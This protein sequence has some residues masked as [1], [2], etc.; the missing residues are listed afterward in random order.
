MERAPNQAEILKDMIRSELY[1]TSNRLRWSHHYYNSRTPPIPFS[2]LQSRKEKLF[3][4]FSDGRYGLVIYFRALDRFP[5]GNADSGILKFKFNPSLSSSY[6]ILVSSY[7]NTDGSASINPTPYPL[8]RTDKATLHKR[9]IFPLKKLIEQWASQ[10][11][12]NGSKFGMDI[13]GTIDVT[14]ED[15]QNNDEASETEWSSVEVLV[16]LPISD[17]SDID[18]EI[19]DFC[20]IFDTENGKE[21]KFLAFRFH[22]RALLVNS[23]ELDSLLPRVPPTTFAE[24]L[25]KGAKKITRLNDKVSLISEQMGPMV[26]FKEFDYFYISPNFLID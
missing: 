6:D 2:D 3:S 1:N 17:R 22:Q 12:T 18:Q 7:S 21:K 23:Q 5:G 14:I 10:A 20:E 9:I 24:E 26:T 19:A 11:G 13:N 15:T 16:Y 8:Y 4:A 25:V